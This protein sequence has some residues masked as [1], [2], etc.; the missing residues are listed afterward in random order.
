MISPFLGEEPRLA[1]LKAAVVRRWMGHRPFREKIYGLA[2]HFP[3]AVHLEWPSGGPLIDEHLVHPV[4]AQLQHRVEMQAQQQGSDWAL[5]QGPPGEVMAP[6]ATTYRTALGELAQEFG[7]PESWGSRALHYC[8]KSA[9]K[10]REWDSQPPKGAPP[11]TYPAEVWTAWRFEPLISIPVFPTTTWRQ[12]RQ[13]LLQQ[14]KAVW[15]ERFAP[16]LE[17]SRRSRRELETHADW[18]FQYIVD[19]RGY[20]SIKGHYNWQGIRSAIDRLISELGMVK[21]HHP[22]GRPR[23]AKHTKNGV[24]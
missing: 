12:L 8:V 1:L 24:Q 23:R 16:L 14:A 22:P 21:P 20:K 19:G 7:W 13:E 2:D 9:G 10:L 5:A 4:A 3:E 17:D 18:L 6:W 15:D 11:D